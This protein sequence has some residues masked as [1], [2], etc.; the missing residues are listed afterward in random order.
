M[1]LLWT[2][3][4]LAVVP[5]AVVREAAGQEYSQPID[6][7]HYSPVYSRYVYDSD[8]SLLAKPGSTNLYRPRATR[9]NA[10][11]G[12]SFATPSSASFLAPIRVD[13]NTM[14]GDPRAYT[15]GQGYGTGY[16]PNYFGVFGQGY[17]IG[18]G[19][20]YF[21]NPGQQYGTGYSPKY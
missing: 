14:R 8:N 7:N 20:N 10:A 6:S 1:R 19:K 17:G 11:T 18:Y 5:W 21:G 15:Y 9:G 4:A 16:S 3:C 12:T 13:G 2:F